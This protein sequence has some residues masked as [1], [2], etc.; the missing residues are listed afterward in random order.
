M[1][2][3]ETQC[4]LSVFGTRTAYRVVL[5][6]YCRLANRIMPELYYMNIQMIKL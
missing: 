3:F 4:S 6:K 5:V 1:D 2:F